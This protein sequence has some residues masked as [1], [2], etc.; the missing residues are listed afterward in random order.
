[1]P[2][3]MRWGTPWPWFI[4]LSLNG[5]VLPTVTRSGGGPARFRGVSD[6]EEVQAPPSAGFQGHFT[7]D[8]WNSPYPIRESSG[9]RTPA[10][11]A[12]RCG[13]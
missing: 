4:M 12:I 1:M 2:T 10:I 8:Y 3:G 6:A 9:M 7:E 11:S 5:G 13:I